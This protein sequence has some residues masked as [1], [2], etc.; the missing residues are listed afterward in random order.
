MKVSF[1]SE[2]ITLNNLH[3]IKL[4][5]G[6][7]NDI[8]IRPIKGK[9]NGYDFKG[10]LTEHHSS[11]YISLSHDWILDNGL[12]VNGLVEVEARVKDI[13]LPPQK[14]PDE[15][16]V[17]L[18]NRGI[19]MSI[20]SFAEKQQ[21]FSSINESRSLEIREKRIEALISS[22]LKKYSRMNVSQI[23]NKKV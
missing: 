17:E 5:E 21:L 10:W 9:I 4:P 11:F 13:S 8:R 16:L 15:L 23:E 19:P 7:L 1:S 20:L 22:C 3:L 12:K 14:A 6:L 18:N 2:L